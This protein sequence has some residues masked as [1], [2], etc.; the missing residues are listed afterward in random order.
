MPILLR[1]LGPESIGLIGFYMAV[2]GVSQILDLGLSPTINREMARANAEG[3]AED[4]HDFLRTVERSY[5][6]VGVVIGLL[7]SASAST[8]ASHW[9]GTSGLSDAE[10][11]RDVTLIG[12]LVA[13]QWPITLYEGALTGLQR[14]AT[15]HMVGIAMRTLGVAGG[16]T[17]LYFGSRALPVYLLSLTVAS[18][19]H[20]LL[21]AALL[22][23]TL[24]PV[25][26]PA[27]WDMR[28]VNRTWRFAAGM[29]VLML[30]SAVLVHADK[31]LLSRLLVLRDFGYYTLGSL[32]ASSLYVLSLP[33]FYAIFPMLSG[34]VASSDERGGREVFHL[35]AQSLAVL[36]I[37]AAAVIVLFADRLLLAWTGS[38]EAAL[39]AAPIAR[40]L[41]VGTALNALMSV[42]YALQLAHGRTKIGIFIHI[43]LIAVFLPAIVIATSRY[44]AIGAASIW[45]GLN[46]LYIVV[47]VPLTH[48]LLM[49][50][51]AGS[52]L[53]RDVLRPSV[54]GVAVAVL[55]WLLLRRLPVSPFIDAVAALSALSMAW[56]AAVL[57]ATRVRRWLMPS[58]MHWL[59]R[60]VEVHP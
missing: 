59:P 10:L 15:M 13:A 1:L 6:L 44:G 56:I 22:H 33:V 27:R 38:V 26:R 2:Q 55:G 37:P 19:V 45:V 18:L 8:L 20:A 24:P 40:L 54:A 14:I 3:R 23:R 30:L 32:I 47:G 29:S 12:L 5:W 39:H 17:L 41:V 57:A 50:G 51:E 52:W 4:A 46:L 43:G 25:A 48:R 35:G 60:H 7:L 11:R 49:P 28:S 34:R 42:P 16:L 9:A 36:V 53:L 31:L 58:V 21:L